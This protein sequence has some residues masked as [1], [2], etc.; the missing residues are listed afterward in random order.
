MKNLAQLHNKIIDGKDFRNIERAFDNYET[1][2]F[3]TELLK[4]FSQ[5]KD[6]QGQ[7]HEYTARNQ[8]RN[9]DPKKYYTDNLRLWIQAYGPAKRSLVEF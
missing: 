4:K 1:G 8:G 7:K 5:E 3:F 6:K 9:E 2:E